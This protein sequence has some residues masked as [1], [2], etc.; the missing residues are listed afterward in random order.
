MKE[1][2]IK[3]GDG[4]YSASDIAKILRVP[5]QKINSWLNKYWDRRFT[6]KDELYTW[7]LDKKK[8][9][10]FYTLI[11]MYIFK[12]FLENGIPIRNIVKAH[13]EL[14][15]ITETEYP[16]AQKE[17]FKNIRTDGKALYYKE[18]LI[19]SLDGSNQTNLSFLVHLTHNIE[20]DENLLPQRFWPAGKG[21]NIIIDPTRQFG[22]PI[23]NN[24]NVLSET[25]TSMYKAGDSIELI[26][27]AFDL[28][29]KDV[30]DAIQFCTTAA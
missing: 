17:I 25:I 21:K 5:Y 24:T 2:E 7:T 12:L 14:S 18:T 28:K 23:I 20:Y 26:A 13:V 8:V 11:E 4:I 3:I 1:R 15:R 6:I 10:N 22:Q 27:H 16:F 30:E 19:I 29:V 9:T